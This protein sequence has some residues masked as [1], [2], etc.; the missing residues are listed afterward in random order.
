MSKGYWKLYAE[1][2]TTS[3]QL[4]DPVDIVMHDN[5]IG[6]IAILTPE[7]MKEFEKNLWVK[8]GMKDK[9][10]LT[11]SV[12]AA[13]WGVVN[14]V[15]NVKQLGGLGV[16]YKIIPHNGVNYF[17]LS[18]FK[19]ETKTLLAGVRY[20]A[21]SPKLG[22]IGV[23]ANN[24]GTLAKENVWINVLWAGGFGAVETVL[25]DQKST[26]DLFAD[27]VIAAGVA[28]GASALSAVTL[29]LAGTMLVSQGIM[30]SVTTCF[31]GWSVQKVVD[32]LGVTERVRDCLKLY[33]N[34]YWAEQVEVVEDDDYEYDDDYYEDD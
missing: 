14:T 18:N 23:C 16:R 33:W 29:P 27:V 2:R 3:D 21:N 15:D 4:R 28:V 6:E 24:I 19:K 32:E 10:L 1:E 11:Q 17:V 9:G 20:K 7:E 31:Y 22:V 12:T 5:V 13:G 30:W 25:N 8:Y 34:E 26:A